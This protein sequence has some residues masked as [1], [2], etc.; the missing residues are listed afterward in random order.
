MILDWQGAAP[1]LLANEND[2]AEAEGAS[3]ATVARYESGTCNEESF[4]SP[5]ECALALLTLV[6]QPLGR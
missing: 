1:Q 6:L 2:N 3:I 4:S 5:E